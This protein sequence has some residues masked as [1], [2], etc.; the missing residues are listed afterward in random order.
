M[1]ACHT[2]EDLLDCADCSYN[3]ISSFVISGDVGRGQ[4]LESDDHM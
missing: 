4:L 1:L 2:D 3:I